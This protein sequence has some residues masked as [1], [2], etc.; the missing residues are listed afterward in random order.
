MT[1]ETQNP[2]LGYTIFQFNPT[3]EF[4]IK[5]LQDLEEERNDGVSLKQPLF[6]TLNL[7]LLRFNE[8]HCLA[9]YFPDSV[10]ICGNRESY[11]HHGK[12]RI[13][14]WIRNQ[15]WGKGASTKGHCQNLWWTEMQ[16]KTAINALKN[17]KYLIVRLPSTQ[18]DFLYYIAAFIYGS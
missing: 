6:K 18:A 8:F 5:T 16:C 7:L 4:H 1:T 17:Q 15:A 3:T 14:G 2:Y 11:R 9:G 12:A 13:E 10:N